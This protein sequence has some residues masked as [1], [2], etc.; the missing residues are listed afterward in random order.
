MR[1][2]A[3]AQDDEAVMRYFANAQDDEAVMTTLVIR[4]NDK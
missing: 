3:N 4:S 2:F 1:S